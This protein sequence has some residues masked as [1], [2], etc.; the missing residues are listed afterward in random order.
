MGSGKKLI[1]KVVKT[2]NKANFLT[3]D[4]PGG[5][6]DPLGNAVAGN[7]SPLDG[8][9]G[10]A[11]KR[12][13]E[14]DA[15][16]AIESANIE[17]TAQR[18]QTAVLQDS[19]RAAQQSAAQAAALDAATRQA[20][21]AAQENMDGITTAPTVDLSLGAAE[22]DS[23]ASRRKRYQSGGRSVGGSSTSGSIR[24]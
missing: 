21:A 13:A 4:L 12:A 22:D 8:M 11:T 15:K 24:L 5:W 18:E 6:D 7:E 23:A 14:S 19:S 2:V 9:T 16:A 20:Q 1:K 3:K 17:A 10:A